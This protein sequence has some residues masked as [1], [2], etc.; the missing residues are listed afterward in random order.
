MRIVSLLPSA[1]EILYAVGAG[2]Q[3]VGVT[4]ECDHP[5]EARAK[6]HLT[7]S[8]LPHL[9]RSA[10]I[11]R[12]VRA[13]LHAGSSIYALDAALLE[14]LA[15]GLII[16]QELCPVCAVS[17]EMVSAATRRLK[18]DPRIVS[19]EPSCLEDVYANILAVGELTGCS[20]GAQALLAALRERER[21]LREL[22]AGRPR[23]STLVLE[24]TDP[25]MSGGHWTPGVVDLAGGDA[26][27]GHA[28]KNSQ[29]LEW[30][31]IAKADPDFVIVAPCGFDL[32]TTEREASALGAND[33]WRGLRAVQSDAVALVDGNAYLNRP[34]PRLIDTAEIFAAALHPGIADRI[35][36]YPQ[37]WKKISRS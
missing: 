6:P 13:N 28:G 4:H 37:G 7:S 10:D 25:P 2:D 17:Y 22:L 24:W 5:I 35:P 3:V 23:P 29:R 21:R 33:V 34:G 36:R 26:V 15:P 9:A 32:Q 19:L 12:H 30:Q 20:D 16:T 1:T 11:D 14:R 31:A 8:S 27:L 18:G